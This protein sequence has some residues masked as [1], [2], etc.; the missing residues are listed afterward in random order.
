VRDGAPNVVSR[1]LVM[2]E[3]EALDVMSAIAQTLG[4]TDRTG[5]IASA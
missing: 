5:R 4:R 1:P 3:A 2:S